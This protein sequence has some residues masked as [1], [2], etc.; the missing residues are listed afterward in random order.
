MLMDEL[1]E[2]MGQPEAWDELVDS[3]NRQDQIVH[4]KNGSSIYLRS[5]DR[6][7]DLRGPNLSWFYID[8]AAKVPHKVWKLM[9]A[10]LRKSPELGWISTTPRGR[11]WIWEEW[12][13]RGRKNY[14]FFTGSTLENK[15]LSKEYKDSLLESYS[16]SFLQQEV[17]GE[18]VGW[19]GLV[20]NVSVDT[21][22]L[23]RPEEEKDG[24]NYSLAGVDWGWIE[25]SVITVGT[26]DGDKR[27]HLVD[28]FYQKKTPID[29]IIE[30]AWRLQELWDIRTFYC[31]PSRPDNI[32]EFRNAGLDARKGKRELDPGIAAVNKYLDEGMLLIDFNNCP[33]TVEE[34]QVYHYEEDDM[35]KILKNKPVDRDNHAMDAVRYMILSLVRAGYAGC[36]GVHR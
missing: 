20:Y 29:K 12:A 3:Y 2:K 14:D 22:H 23:D 8:E 13:K 28:E 35:G 34:A 31:D 6:P 15:H 18:F 16:G 5:C 21:H 1:W 36:R 17:Y 33:R 9:V 26:V 25:P 27:V 24:Y 4:F 7:D 19:E 10:R 11:N 32:Q 30:E